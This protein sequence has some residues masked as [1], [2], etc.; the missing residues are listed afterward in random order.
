M[1]PATLAVL[2]VLAVAPVIVISYV[3]ATD[4][5]ER[6][7]S[8]QAEIVVDGLENE[9]RDLLDPVVEQLGYARQAVMDGQLNPHDPD[10]LRTFVLGLLGGT[11]Q[12]FGIGIVREDWSMLRW[13]R[14]G[15]AE[16]VEPPERLPFA[17]EAVE[18]AQSG[19]VAYWARPFVSLVLGDTILN[20]R[21]ALERDGEFLG[22]LSAGV[23]SEGLARYIAEASELYDVTAFVLAGRDR[24]IVY[25]GA[26]APREEITST[27]L[28]RLSSVGN[29]A[30]ARMWDDPQPFSQIGDLT[31][32]QGHWSYIDDVAQIY[33][34]RELNGYGPEPLIVA[35]ARLGADTWR[36]RWAATIAAGVGFVLML[37]AIG[38]AWRIG[39]ALSRPAADFDGALGAIAALEFARVSLPRLVGSRVREW[40]AM[41]RRL[42]STA[43]ALTAFRT[44]LPIALVRR[45][46][47]TADAA[48]E[49]QERTVTVMFA[50][51]E[52]F[53]AFSRGRTASEVA[54]HLNEV[55]GLIG[56]IIEATDGVIDK[57]TGD[58]LL[59]FWGAPD[60]QPD[61]AH[62]ACSAA[63][64]IVRALEARADERG[65]RTPR[66][67][68]GLHTGPAIVGNIGF[69]GR[70]NYTLVGDTVNVAERTQ[71]AL[72]GIQPNRPAVL[73][74]THEV[75][76]AVG[77]SGAAMRRGEPLANASH[78]A[79]MLRPTEGQATVVSAVPP[80][81][82]DRQR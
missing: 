30:I 82:P 13:E 44:Y 25:P 67:R 80:A 1:L 34:Y 58:G 77:Q 47:D 54:D 69:P 24:V 4:T 37:V 59:A 68:I 10:D 51:L 16:V 21:V 17:G 22:V 63:V 31:R 49:S 5:A 76:A 66:L 45:L 12:V 38:I 70:I 36:D 27:E 72:R 64:D 11:P 57:Y 56:P 28:P 43:R 50:D 81:T 41:A 39:R 73:A 23:T 14:D 79:V 55:F 26:Q 40:R 19:R 8:Q 6:L 32:S 18:A 15:F 52:G 46:F 20:Y 53:T 75:L 65:A 7:L 62:R 61:H 48:V 78:P 9:I 60:T 2:V 71:A 42:E 33:F 29:P 3:V 35:V 74:A